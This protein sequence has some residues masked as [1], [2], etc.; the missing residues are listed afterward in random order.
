[1]YN[2]VSKKYFSSLDLFLTIK[3]KNVPFN[4]TYTHMITLENC[5]Q[6]MINS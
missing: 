6:Q 4:E 2:S 1:M 3:K 5:I